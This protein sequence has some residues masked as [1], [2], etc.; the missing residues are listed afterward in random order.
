MTRVRV[1]LAA[2]I[3]AFTAWNFMPYAGVAY[4]SCQTM[5]SGLRAQRGQNNHLFMPQAAWSDLADAVELDVRVSPEP[6]S[7]RLAAMARF[8][9][10]GRGNLEAVRVAVA[11]LCDAGLEVRVAGASACDDPRLSRPRWWLPFSL[12]AVD[13]R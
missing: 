12:Y 5:F 4:N 9:A 6:T 10:R 2:L 8:L 1:V 3:V 13:G 7:R 11:G